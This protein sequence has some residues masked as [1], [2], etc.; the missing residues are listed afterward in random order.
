MNI[1][2]SQLVKLNAC[3]GGIEWYDKQDTDDLITLVKAAIKQEKFIAS[4]GET[5]NTLSFANWGIIAIMTDEQR[6]EY[7]IYAAYQVAY[8]WKNKYPKKFKIWDEWASGRDRGTA[9]RAAAWAAAYNK[10]LAKILRYGVKV[11]VGKVQCFYNG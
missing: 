11:L 4:N 2:K 1:T 3:E 9:T 7:A 10:M 8:L 6:R 5:E